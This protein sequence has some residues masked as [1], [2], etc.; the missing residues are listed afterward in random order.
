VF[1]ASAG[2]GHRGENVPVTGSFERPE[3]PESTDTGDF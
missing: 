1:R 2:A 3:M